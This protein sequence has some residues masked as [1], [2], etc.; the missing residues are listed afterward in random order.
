MTLRRFE[1][2]TDSYGADLKRWPEEE[3]GTA[4]A[5]LEV[6]AQAR[7]RIAEAAELDEA[8]RAASSR[9]DSALWPG[10][11]ADAAL[12]RLRSSVGAQITQP[13]HKQTA[14]TWLR[15]DPVKWVHLVASM[16]PGWPS[17][18]A[19][20]GLAVVMGLLIGSADIA[21]PPPVNLL[22]MLQPSPIQILSN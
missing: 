19:S 8:L 7:Q 16:Q 13:L 15:W 21:R 11:Q 18:A 10:G 4:A 17:L 22:T 12:A 2:L 20:G 3:R 9:A 5:L 6:S 14:G 1:S